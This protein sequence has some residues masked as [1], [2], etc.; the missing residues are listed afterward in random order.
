MRY[1]FTVK[2]STGLLRYYLLAPNFGDAENQLNA[3]EP[4]LVDYKIEKLSEEEMVWATENNHQT[5]Y[6]FKIE[7]QDEIS[8]EIKTQKYLVSAANVAIAGTVIQ[9]QVGPNFI[10]IIS[11]ERQLVP[12]INNAVG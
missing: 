2:D 7:Y 1:V 9:N 5:L 4:S 8:G 3:L 10:R 12:L 6:V 11:I